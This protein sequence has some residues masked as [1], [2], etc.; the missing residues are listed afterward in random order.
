[1]EVRGCT[2]IDLTEESYTREFRFGVARDGWVE[3]KDAHSALF[4]IGSG[5]HVG[6]ALLD[7]HGGG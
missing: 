5:L 2:L 7:E 6:M 1:M 3:E 4:A